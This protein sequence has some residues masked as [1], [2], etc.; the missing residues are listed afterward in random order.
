MS[1]DE[2]YK[3]D[4]FLG[5]MEWLASMPEH[6][7]DFRDCRAQGDVSEACAYVRDGVLAP[8]LAKLPVTEVIDAL[9]ET[10][11]W[12]LADLEDLDTDELHLK[13]IFVYCPSRDDLEVMTEGES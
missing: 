11:G 5:D 13:L 7:S 12:E 8:Y 1:V 3:L 9:L 6:N 10:G 4:H 2:S